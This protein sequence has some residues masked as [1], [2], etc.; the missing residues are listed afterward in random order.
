MQE[1]GGLGARAGAGRR[2]DRFAYDPNDPVATL[3]GNNCCGTPI[4]GPKDQRPLGSRADVLSYERA[5]RQ[6]ARD[7]GPGGVQAV[8]GKR[9]ARHR[10]RRQADRRPRR[11]LRGEHRR[12]HPARSL[13]SGHGSSSLEPGQV[14]E[15]DLDLIGTANVF[16]AGH[17]VQVLITSS[18]F[19]QF[20]R[21]P[22]TGEAFGRSAITRVAQQTICHGPDRPSHLLLPVVALPDASPLDR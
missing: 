2:P 14:H 13:S 16:L 12:G 9:R 18:H 11:W 22:N 19:P 6:A 3:G 7:R 4:A 8:R 20:D 10:L 17:R 15:L 21:N 5:A 1:C